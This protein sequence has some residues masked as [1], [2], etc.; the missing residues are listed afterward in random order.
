MILP[1]LLGEEKKTQRDFVTL[2]TEVNSNYFMFQWTE[3]LKRKISKKKKKLQ[4]VF[5]VHQTL[6]FQKIM[7]KSICHDMT[8]L[9][10]YCTNPIRTSCT[11]LREKR[12]LKWREQS[13]KKKTHWETKCL[14]KAWIYSTRDPFHHRTTELAK[15]SPIRQVTG[16]LKPNQLVSHSVQW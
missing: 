4:H 9:R 5:I 13:S 14:I 15:S 7:G 2:F 11:E 16:Y 3:R 8:S 1:Y 6:L 12:T 10:T